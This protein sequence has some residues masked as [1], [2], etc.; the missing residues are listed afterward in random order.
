MIPILFPQ[1]ETAFTSNGIGR[2]P[3]IISCIVTEERNG[4]SV[5]A[6]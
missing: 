1:A 4:K 6:A 3:D 2:L 5:R